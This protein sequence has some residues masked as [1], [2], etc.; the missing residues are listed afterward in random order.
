[1]SEPIETAVQM[2]WCDIDG[3]GHVSHTAALTYLEEGRDA[4]L[5]SHGID[6]SEYVI[7][8]CS[9][10]YR[11]EIR[12]AEREVTASCAVAEVRRSSLSTRERLLDSSGNVFV[13]ADF[14]IVLW[15]SEKRGSRPLTDDERASLAPSEQVRA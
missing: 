14:G 8:S 3:L 12:L 6:R 4:M 11:S 9:V 15:D 13:E 1:V 5:E 2:R 7:G 10:V